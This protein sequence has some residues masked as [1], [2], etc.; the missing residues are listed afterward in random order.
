LGGQLARTL[1]MTRLSE[2]LRDRAPDDE[3]RTAADR[4]LQV[5]MGDAYWE[6]WRFPNY[7]SMDPVAFGAFGAAMFDQRPLL[8]RLA[9]IACPTLVMVGE[10][11]GGFLATSE[12]L[13][14]GIPGAKVALIP[15]AGHQ[16]Q[17]ETPAAWLDALIAFL[18]F[19]RP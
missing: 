9:E 10:G 16:P 4:R 19:V 3:T 7:R 1:G 18:A 17:L 12:E 13:A 14:R 11:D 2:I 6:Q 5:E 15:D 8:D